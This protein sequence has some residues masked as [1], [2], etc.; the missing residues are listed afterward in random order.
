MENPLTEDFHL[1]VWHEF[2]HPNVNQ[3]LN[4]VLQGP[5]VVGTVPRAAGVV[6]TEFVGIK[7]R[8]GDIELLRR[9]LYGEQ[10]DLQQA[11]QY[12]E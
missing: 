5:T 9:V 2:Q 1:A 4:L 8:R 10:I 7:A 3:I 6:N 12:E 11:L